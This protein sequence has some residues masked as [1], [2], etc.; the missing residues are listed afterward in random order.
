MGFPNLIAAAT[1]SLGAYGPSLPARR[2]MESRRTNP[3][4]ENGRLW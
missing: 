1:V 2:H 3:I 4:P